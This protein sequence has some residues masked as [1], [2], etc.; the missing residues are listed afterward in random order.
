MKK[1]K[2]A[3]ASPVAGPVLFL[4]DPHGAQSLFRTE[5]DDIFGGL[6]NQL[7]TLSESEGK[8]RDEITMTGEELD[9]LTA[10]WMAFRLRNLR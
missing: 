4:T 5:E 10:Q 7:F 9:S 1:E 6:G 3:Q 2:P 8:K